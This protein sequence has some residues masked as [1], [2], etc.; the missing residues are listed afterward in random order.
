V[1]RRMTR[2]FL[3][4]DDGVEVCTPYDA[5]WVAKIKRAIPP[6][7]RFWDNERKLWVFD[8]AVLREVRQ[9]TD[10]FWTLPP[11][12]DV[13]SKHKPPP[14]PP[15]WSSP[16]PNSLDMELA[17]LIRDVPNPALAKIYRV[18]IAS[19]H[20]DAG[21]DHEKAVAINQAWDRIRAMRGL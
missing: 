4:T 9:I 21:G 20:P 19:V 10:M 13:R 5:E 8:Y 17:A 12:T 18:A 6:H 14:P 3:I 2:G 11:E 1:T 7:Q 16:R 15:P